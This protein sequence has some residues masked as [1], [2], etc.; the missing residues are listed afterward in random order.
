[1]KDLDGGTV[2]LGSLL[3]QNSFFR[4]PE[5]QRPYSWD[6]ENS[7]QVYAEQLKVIKTDE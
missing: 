3:S 1:M 2:A 4:I 7:V 5:Y 6:K